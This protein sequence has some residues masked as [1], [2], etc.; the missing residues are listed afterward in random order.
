[1]EKIFEKRDSNFPEYKVWKYS[2]DFAQKPK[3][4][5]YGIEVSRLPLGGRLLT[6]LIFVALI[7][8]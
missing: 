7:T 6:M 3:R 2:L 4:T 1:M 8:L 5:N